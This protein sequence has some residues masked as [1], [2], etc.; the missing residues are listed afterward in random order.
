MK[1]YFLSFMLFFILLGTATAGYAQKVKTVRAEYTYYAPENVSLEEAKHTAMQRAQVMALG[2]EFGTVVSQHNSTVTENSG[3]KSNI[4]F[5]SLSTSDVK[6]EW[7][8]TTDGPHYEISYQKDMLVVRCTLQGK[9]RELVSADMSFV[10]KVLRNGFADTNESDSFRNGD[11]MY[12]SFTTPVKGYLAVYL[13]DNAQNAYCL[14][15]YRSEESGMVA[16]KAN[17]NYV[18]FS[19]KTAAPYFNPKDVDEYVLTSDGG[20]ETNYLYVIFSP[21]AFTKAAD[22]EAEGLPRELKFE[23]FQRWLA[24]N[25]THDKKMQVDIKTLTVKK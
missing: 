8:E 6:G 7:I 13:V 19:E 21:N 5:T 3:T 18:L 23:Q 1:Q 24:K 11:S 14:L 2:E 15:P 22:Q 10:S 20:V 12:L 16:V 9:V 4:D 25:R 17:H